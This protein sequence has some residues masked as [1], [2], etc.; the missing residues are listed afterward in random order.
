MSNVAA[1]QRFHAKNPVAARALVEKAR[2]GDAQSLEAL[3][4]ET[5]LVAPELRALLVDDAVAQMFGVGAG[6]SA[7][8]KKIADTSLKTAGV[9][10][11]GTVAHLTG[12]RGVAFDPSSAKNVALLLPF[13]AGKPVDGDAH[14]LV[15]GVDAKKIEAHIG[16]SDVAGMVRL[17]KSVAEAIVEKK[18]RAFCESIADGVAYDDPGHK[19]AFS[20]GLSKR[21]KEAR[22][23][24]EPAN[25]IGA[26]FSMM[27]TKA[28]LGVWLD[29]KMGRVVIAEDTPPLPPAVARGID[30]ARGLPI[31]RSL[32]SAKRPADDETLR[33]LASS[34]PVSALE[35]LKKAN[36]QV[37]F[38]PRDQ[39]KGAKEHGV[40]VIGATAAGTLA[41]DND[42]AGGVFELMFGA[43]AIT[44]DVPAEVRATFVR[45]ELGHAL[46]AALAAPGDLWLSNSPELQKIYDDTM[47]SA[48]DGGPLAPPTTYAGKN[49]QEMFAEAVAMYTGGVHANGQ[50]DCPVHLGRAH[51]A[52]ANP[53]LYQFM[54][55][56][57]GDVIPSRLAAGDTLGPESRARLPERLMKDLVETPA[58]KRSSDDLYTLAALKTVVGSST[59]DKASLEE[60]LSLCDELKKKK[61]FGFIPNKAVMAQADELAGKIREHL[62][63]LGP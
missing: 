21:M 23:K 15:E 57:F 31:A 10:V 49:A 14:K 58:K 1:L 48:K 29:A 42:T 37:E 50:V 24:N 17:D 5:G 3:S 34:F 46:D 33:A 62:A 25:D 19:D 28:A 56:L 59:G 39:V 16:G 45:H 60:A 55:R 30:V 11:G 7:W 27:T 9:R 47:A 51:L 13:A 61:L 6:K 52:E 63:K 35:V 44:N 4:R 2:G 22:D 26:F 18:R 41:T 40:D 12:F 43:I 38:V 36:V 53:P 20:A 54:E 8:G 32:S